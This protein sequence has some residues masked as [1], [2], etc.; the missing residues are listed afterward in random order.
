MAKGWNSKVV[1][2]HTNT[3]GDLADE[4]LVLKD[5]SFGENRPSNEVDRNEPLQGCYY[6]LYKLK[7]KNDRAHNRKKNSERIQ[8]V[9]R[10]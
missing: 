5:Y 3:K 4:T 1:N 9:S 10:D 6:Q 2:E 7:P 8:P